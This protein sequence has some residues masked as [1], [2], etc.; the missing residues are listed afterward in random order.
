MGYGVSGGIE[1]VMIRNQ[2]GTSWGESGYAR[3]KMISGNTGVCGL[4]TDNTFTLVGY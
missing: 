3:V 2:W 4:Y 1:Y